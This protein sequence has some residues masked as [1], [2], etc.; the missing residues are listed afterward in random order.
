MAQITDH[1]RALLR[2][3]L[4][5]LSM[6]QNGIS[7]ETVGS[8][9]DQL[10]EDVLTEQPPMVATATLPYGEEEGEEGEDQRIVVT[11][12]G[13][14]TPLGI[15]NEQYWSGLAAGKSGITRYTLCDPSEYP[16][17]VAGEVKAFNPQDFM[18][19]K[20]A[21]RMSRAGQFAVAAARLAMDDAGL[22]I[23]RLDPYEIGALIASGTTSFPDTEKAV[24]AMVEKGPTKVSPLYVP[25]AMPNMPS[26][27]VAI[28]LGLRG[29]NTAICTACAAGSQ[30]IGE[31]ANVIRRGEANIML[32]GG[33]EAPISHLGLASFCS[34]RALSTSFNDEPERASRPFDLRRD[35]FVAGE[36]AAVL[37]LERLSNARRRGACIYAELVGYG[38]TCDAYHITAPDPDGAGAAE[39]IRRALASAGLSPQQIDYINAHGTSTPAGDVS[40]TRAIKH[41]FGEYAYSVPISS[42]KSMIGHL[43][44]AAGAVEAAATVLI[45]NGGI[46]PPTINQEY[47]DPECDLDYV[48]NGARPAPDMQIVMSNSFGFGGI[49]SV[50]IFRKLR[51]LEDL[52]D[53]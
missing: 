37:V 41:V 20:E 4:L 40:E 38:T 29:Y 33:A 50:L 43:T 27:Q 14:V 42:T 49:N 32:A 25:S 13:P 39:A 46:I 6:E 53:I 26:C 51:E 47:P 17:Q 7:Q 34:M 12:V 35:G 45:L 21:R 16:S 24:R 3:R 23:D 36:G 8:Q 2:E 28:Q 44:G 5:M 19:S 1:Q 18:D 11:G 52:L 10:L 30:A 15:G 9:I 22:D 48:P 31:A